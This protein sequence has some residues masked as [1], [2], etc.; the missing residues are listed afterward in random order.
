MFEELLMECGKIKAS[1]RMKTRAVYNLGEYNGFV[2]TY[3]L[4][5]CHPSKTEFIC[6]N[7][8]REL[9]IS[10]QDMFSFLADRLT[11]GVTVCAN[12]TCESRGIY[13]RSSSFSDADNASLLKTHACACS[14]HD[15]KLL[16]LMPVGTVDDIPVLVPAIATSTNGGRGGV[17]MTLKESCLLTRH[18]LLQTY[19][20]NAT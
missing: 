15:T 19:F 2:Y 10:V 7:C 9:V 6:F 18:P 16:R 20:G 8:P 3:G 17:L 1:D 11:S 5:E 4:A 13:Y 12:Q 14:E